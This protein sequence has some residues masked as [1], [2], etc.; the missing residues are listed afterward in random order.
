MNRK[1]YFPTALHTYSI[2]KRG[3]N[4]KLSRKRRILFILIFVILAAV[5]ICKGYLKEE[6]GR[7]EKVIRK[8]FENVVILSSEENK[9]S[10]MIEGKRL[11]LES[12]AL[13]EKYEGVMAD[14]VVENDI[15]TEIFLK[16]DVIS[17]K[18]LSIS[19]TGIEIEGYGMVAALPDYKVY[20]AYDGFRE[21]DKSRINVGDEGIKF[22][23]ADKVICGI[24]I[25]NKINGNAKNI[26]VLLK[27]TGFLGLFHENVS[28][29]SDSKFV[30]SH[31]EKNENGDLFEV[32]N[33][34]EA[35]SNYEVTLESKEFENGRIVIKIPDNNGKI[36]INSILRNGEIPDY[37]GKIEIQKCNEGLVIINELSIEEYLYAV[38]PSE[39]PSSYGVEALKVQAVCA[40]SYAVSHLANKRL[41]MYGAQVDDSTDY[42][43]YRNSLE[44]E[45]SINAVDDTF[46][47]ILKCGEG[48]ANTYFFATSCG[49]TTDSTIWGGE[50]LP[51]IKEKILT[52]ESTNK[53]LSNEKIFS[54]FI[55]GKDENFDDESVWYRWN[56][57]LSAKEISEIVNG[58]LQKACNTFGKNILVLEKGQ[59]VEKSISNIGQVK[60]ISVEKR[61]A[62]GIIEELV[63]KGEK[64]TIKIVKQ[65]AIRN[66]FN[67]SGYILNRNDGSTIDTMAALPSAFFIVE[68]SESGFKFIGG[69]Y[70]HGAGMSQTAVKQMIAEGMN[71][72]EIL[73][74]FYTDVEIH[75]AY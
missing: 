64:A 47:Q 21:I 6:K 34:Y 13:T 26:R 44:S 8:E 23:V 36:K 60:G 15:V 14:I 54:E 75:N 52:K 22:I 62:G 48:I 51:Y 20:A 72:E 31:Y 38:I 70:G 35:A 71:Y 37:R 63:I 19:D 24:F 40:R 29:S 43:V 7:Q 57:S 3:V 65:S 11:D 66:L 9:I 68:N 46:G 5:F 42:Q 59:Y 25:E 2:E 58:N 28:I 1:E 12:Y 33:E 30:V 74:F 18:I 61:G 53:D 67:I 69:G 27:T 32:S 10:V 73:K 39:M 4:M 41:S 16:R 55:K 50:K 49:S 56:I 17:G 45:N